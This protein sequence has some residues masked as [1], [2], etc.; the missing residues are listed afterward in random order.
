MS[1]ERKLTVRPS[2]DEAHV[3]PIVRILLLVVGGLVLL[4]LVSLL[5]GLG[6]LFDGASI[7]LEAIVIALGTY[8]V[9]GALVAVGARI[10]SLVRESL[11]GPTTVIDDAAASVKYL[12]VFVALVIAH[13]GFSGALV[14]MFE[15]VGTGWLYHLLFL[16]AALVPL[17]LI[18]RR[19]YRSLDPV[20]ELLTNEIVGTR[21]P[22]TGGEGDVGANGE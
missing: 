4:G 6:V 13:Q 14:P 5:P 8:L 3:Y 16:A 17:V 9:A 22:A 12:F 7:P 1:D 21:T 10:E 11:E 2:I 19:L 18:A 20:A 15:A